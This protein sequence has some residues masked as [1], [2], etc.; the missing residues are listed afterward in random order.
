VK[1]F[2]PRTNK[3]ATFTG[4]IS[5]HYNR[6]QTLK[7]IRERVRIQERDDKKTSKVSTSELQKDSNCLEDILVGFEASEPLPP[8][9]PEKHHQ[10]SPSRRFPMNILEQ[11]H[12]YWDDPAM[13]VCIIMSQSMVKALLI[14]FI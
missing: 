2:Y 13:R 7:K 12:K 1:R 3:G 6:E 5:K 14:V 9:S 11:T 10:I 8:A 4:Q